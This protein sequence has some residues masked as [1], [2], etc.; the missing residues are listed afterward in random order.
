MSSLLGEGS[1]FDDYR[2]WQEVHAYIDGL[3][4]K[5]PD[6]ATV[7]EVGKTYEGRPMKAITLSTQPN[8]GKP[9]LW[10][11]GGLHAREWITVPTVTYVADR[12]LNEY[13][14]GSGN[15][16][17]HMLD[18]FDV[19]VVPILNVDGFDYT[20]NGDRMWRKT[21]TPNE[22]SPCDGTDPNRNW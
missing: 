2:T 1:Y 3:A 8:S 17:T 20:W 21:R 22:K 5:F 14:S 19:I 9:T 16:S 15:N 10:F 6:L 13:Q 18:E 12:L 11:D 7:W 4:E